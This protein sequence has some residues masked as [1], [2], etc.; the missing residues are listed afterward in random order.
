MQKA[1]RCD[2]SEIYKLKLSNNDYLSTRLVL[3]CTGIRP[4]IFLAKNANIKVDKG[5]KVNSFLESSVKDVY[6]S[7]D[8]AEINDKIFG[9]W[10]TAMKQGIVAARNMLD[11]K[12]EINLN[13]PQVTL[14]IAGTEIVSFGNFSAKQTM[15]YS[16]ENIYRKIFIKNDKI[17]G[18][19]LIGDSTAKASLWNMLKKE[20]I[21]KINE[22]LADPTYKF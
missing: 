12:E 7:G 22:N 9:L 6:A 5:I 4:N 17:T 18:V 16:T 10:T 8:C 11:H 3:I 2:S 14:K 13:T 21:I 20:S 1:S 19:I 15:C